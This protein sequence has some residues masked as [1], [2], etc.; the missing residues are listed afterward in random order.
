M[1][2]LDN[3]AE[4][5]KNASILPINI[6]KI[7]KPK[8]IVVLGMGTPNTVGKILEPWCK[9][10][11]VAID[12]WTLPAW[13]GKETLVLALSYSGNTGEV[14]TTTKKSLEQNSNVIGI[15]SGGELQ[16]LGISNKF[17]AITFE[18][19]GRSGHGSWC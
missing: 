3:W 13:V 16:S 7:L 6:P 11:L 2:N 8:N 17:P 18:P 4:Y 19:V 5:A 9:V 10:P 14:L 12:D 1:D 15:S